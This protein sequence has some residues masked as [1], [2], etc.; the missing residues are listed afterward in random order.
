[1]ALVAVLA[2]VAS[3]EELIL[4]TW[5][6]YLAPELIDE[7]KQ[8]TGATLKIVVFELDEA[9]DSLLV[10]NGPAA[11]D[12]MVMGGSSIAGYVRRGWL[13]PI[14]KAAIPNLVHLKPFWVSA[15]DQSEAYGVPYFWGTTG[16][17]YRSDLVEE[18]FHSWRQLLQPAE[19]L[20]GRIAM[21]GAGRD[22]ISPVLKMMGK[23][24]NVTDPSVI[25]D[26]EAVLRAQKPFVKTYVYLSM[27]RES[28]LVTGEVWA[29][30]AYNG[31]ARALQEFEPAI[32]FV[33]PE[34]G[35]NLYADYLTISS[36]SKKKQLAAQFIDFLNRPDVAARNALFVKYASPNRA[37][38]ALLPKEYLQDPAIY[39]S[40][41]AIQRSEI[42]ESLSPRLYKSLNASMIRLMN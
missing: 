15:H 33:V 12:L 5:A 16:I 1:M 10:T 14:D 6:E 26:A 25:Q 30:L 20:R 4:L 27:T 3:A 22:L 39:P 18:P 34:E 9:R 32:R 38:E 42:Y 41:S 29:A 24:V 23:S 17:A 19:Y 35:S 36:Q 28:T 40:E 11:Y 2:G 13:A 31:G 7:F 37:A 8:E 21:M